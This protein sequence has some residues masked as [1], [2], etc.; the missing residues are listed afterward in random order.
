MKLRQKDIRVD[1][2]RNNY[3]LYKY[4]QH[5]RGL[6]LD[7]YLSENGIDIDLT[8]YTIEAYFEVL[9]GTVYKKDCTPDGNKIAIIIDEEITTLPGKVVLE[10]V[11]YDADRYITTPA[12]NFRVEKS[13]SDGTT[14][15]ELT[16]LL[17]SED[18]AL[19]DKD[20]NVLCSSEINVPGN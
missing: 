15:V 19:L 17:D 20:D 4:K 3:Q 5:D 2:K 14:T 6:E 16:Y 8:S 11:A 13:I 10:V 1:L 7:L 9:D 18:F 12:I